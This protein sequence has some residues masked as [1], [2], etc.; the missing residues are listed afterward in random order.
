MSDDSKTPSEQLRQIIRRSPLSIT[1]MARLAGI[2]KNTIH[3]YISHRNSMQMKIVDRLAPVL[4]IGMISD[5]RDCRLAKTSPKKGRPVG[6][7]NKPR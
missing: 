2:S 5:G 7:K 6:S 1:H 3:A 4:G